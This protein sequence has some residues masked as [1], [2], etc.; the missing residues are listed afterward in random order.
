M[1][2]HRHVERR[3]AFP[4]YREFVGVEILAQSVVIDQRPGE[5]ELLDAA[6]QF[7]S[8]TGGILKR[9]VREAAEAP[10]VARDPGGEIIV[11]LAG[12]PR[13]LD[14]VFLDLHAG[15]RLREHHHV[16][17]GRVHQRDAFVV[18]I[19]EFRLIFFTPAGLKCAMI[20]PS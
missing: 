18:E 13:R 4:K 1:Q 17:A 9:Q 7:I 3:H 6:L 16:D 5:A 15:R 2:I 14:G 19:R 8:G 20:G 11:R 10:G 12:E